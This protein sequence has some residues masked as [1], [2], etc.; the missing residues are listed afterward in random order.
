MTVTLVLPA[1]GFRDLKLLLRAFPGPAHGLPGLL[2]RAKTPPHLA[3]L[4]LVE[5]VMY[6]WWSS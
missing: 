4:R 6:G 3:T 1:Q 2:E 5:E